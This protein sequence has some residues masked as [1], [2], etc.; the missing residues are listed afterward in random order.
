MDRESGAKMGRYDVTFIC[1]LPP[2][3][4]G[5]TVKDRLMLDHILSS[6]DVRTIDMI[7]CKK[8]PWKI[9]LIS[10]QVAVGMLRSKAV[11]IGMGSTPRRKILLTLQKVLTGRAGLKKV[12]LIVM[13]GQFH[14]QMEKD[15]RL[16]DLLKNTG[17][18][19]VESE[20]MID[21]LKR[22]G[23]ERTYLFPNCR[24]S[25]GE[26]PPRPSVSGEK[27]RLVFFSRICV[28]KG[29]EDII[30]AY[31]LLGAD[32]QNVTLDFYGGIEDDIRQPFQAFIVRNDNVTYCGVFDAVHEDVYAELNQYDVMLLMS[33]RE[34]VAGALVESKMAGITAIVS[35]RGLNTE[36]VQDG[37]EGLVVTEPIAESLAA[38]IRKL[39][40]DRAYLAQLKE[41][42]YASR[43]RYL[44][45]SYRQK[46]L[47][48]LSGA[49]GERLRPDGRR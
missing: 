41:G 47:D 18:I 6:A 37:T 14:E 20:Q 27:L 26:R 19:W 32:A 24:P 8:K 44:V 5:V 46:L 22:Q 42:A 17:S 21:S 39:I 45:D 23:I 9:P 30:A 35:D 1:E 28:E 31:D 10:V 43:K 2:P 15:S 4:G 25:G 3:Y 16:R 49:A 48:V 40:H 38:A 34:G 13:G 11:V 7:E 12:M 36:T 33:K 29:V